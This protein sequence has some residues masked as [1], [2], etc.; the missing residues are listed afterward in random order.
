VLS[1][2]SQGPSRKIATATAAIV[3]LSL[4]SV[5]VSVWRYEVAIR[6]Q[7]K[8]VDALEQSL[9]SQSVL[10]AFHTEVEAMNVYMSDQSRTTL[11]QVNSSSAAVTN[12]AESLH[13]TGAAQGLV[14]T[15][16][17]SN[18]AFI[19][20]YHKTLAQLPIIGIPPATAILAGSEGT[21]IKPLEGLQKLFQQQQVAREHAASNA[22]KE[23][24]ISALVASVIGVALA[25]LLALYSVRLVGRLVERLRSSALFFAEVVEGMRRT[26]REAL[27]ATTEQSSAVAETSATIEQLAGTASAISENGQAVSAAAEETERTMV[28]V[29]ETVESIAARSLGLGESSQ[30]IGEILELITGIAEQTNLLAL[31][32]AIEAARAGEAGRGFAVVAAEVRKLAER[33]M[34]STDS[35][36]AIVDEIR[37]ETN[38]TILATEQGARQT[39]EVGALM[40]R[41]GEM[42]EDALLTVQQQN[43]AVEQVASA[44]VQI[45]AAADQLASDQHDRLADS[46]NAEKLVETVVATL[47]RYG[48]D[49]QGNPGSPGD[50]S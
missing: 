40:V 10:T 27:A 18:Q 3:A 12:L 25:I 20:L 19:T 13:A 24:W 37:S 7:Q 29:Q 21:V 46:D 14:K 15:A 17:R 23:A 8:A 41:T 42:I 44:M 16:V 28:Q 1:R 32:A 39:K 30:Q 49:L 35:I 22:R 50:P 38:A 48:I 4:L 9:V 36:R 31:N 33:S 6:Q 43:S 11:A 2:L 26:G 45:R 34:Q 47:D 5:S